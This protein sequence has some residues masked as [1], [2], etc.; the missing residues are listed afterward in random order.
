MKSFY[1][2]MLGRRGFHLEQCV[3]GG[4]VGTDYDVREDLTGKL[5]ESW[6]E[7]NRRFIPVILA[8]RPG[9]TRIGAGLACGALWTVSKGMKI[10]DVVLSPDGAGSYRVGEV[11]SDYYFAR[12]QSLPHRRRVRWL[13][14]TI[15]RAA[16]GESL[17][18][19][20]AATGTVVD[21]SRHGEEIERLLGWSAA[22]GGAVVPV[23]AGGASEVEDPAAFAMEKHLEDFLVQNWRQTEL[24]RDFSI[25][26]EEGELVG[27]QY[28]T[29]AGPIDIL[30]VS[31]D[32]KR[33]L[34][35]ELKRGR[36]SD[37]VV[38]QILRYM[39][40]V[41]DQVAEPGQSV[42]GAIIALTDDQKLRWAIS[43]VPAITFFRYEVSFRLVR[44]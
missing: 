17:Q 3:A 6:R 33:L 24:S 9:K 20:T 15:A 44:A 25:F 31:K 39:G 1:R 26:E 43:A 28:A 29:D 14:A 10:G 38:G 11:T 19:S 30:A 5:P 34:V 37:V 18:G 22:L 7:F 42:E 12:G 41:K 32:G 13:D 23:V 2:I 16:M 36:A 40:F 4:F 8:A 21:V 35:V 27:Q